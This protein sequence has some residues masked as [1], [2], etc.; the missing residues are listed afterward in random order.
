MIYF[1]EYSDMNIF[2]FS[3]ENFTYGE[4]LQEYFVISF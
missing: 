4:K 3:N 1:L 2:K